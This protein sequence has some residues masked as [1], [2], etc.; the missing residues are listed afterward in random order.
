MRT[1][2]I[3]A[4]FGCGQDNILAAQL[5]DMALVWL[6]MVIIYPGGIHLFCLFSGIC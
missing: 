3:G 1:Q 4:R 5:A 6:V 2:R